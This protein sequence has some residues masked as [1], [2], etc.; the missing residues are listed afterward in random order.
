MERP[1]QQLAVA[2][3]DNVPIEGNCQLER[4]TEEPHIRGPI[5]ARPHKLDPLCIQPRI[6]FRRQLLQPDAQFANDVVCRLDSERF[7]DGADE[8]ARK[9][10]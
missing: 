1:T 9:V 2:S 10:G 7:V 5:H 4:L 6:A 8:V 3:A